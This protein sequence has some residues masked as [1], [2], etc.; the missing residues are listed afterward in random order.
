[1]L[2][3]IYILVCLLG[4]LSPALAQ[5]YTTSNA[6]S[7]N[8]YEQ[9]KPFA[10]AFARNFGSMEAD[11][12]ERNGELYVAHNLKDIDSSRTLKALY[13]QPLQNMI[14]ANKGIFATKAQLQLLID[15][16]TAGEPTMKA[17][18]QALSAFPAITA[19]QQVKIVISGSRPDPAL[20][21]QYPS[22][23]LFDGIPTVIYTPAQ[24]RKIWMISDNFRNYTK[25]NG[26]GSIVKEEKQPIEAVIKKVHALGKK[27]R[28][29][30]TPDNVNTWKTMINLRVDYLN[31]DKVDSL[32][33]YLEKRGTAHLPEP[34]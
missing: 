24:L 28:F 2:R 11:V 26:K 18:I 21:E 16:K 6:H 1:M 33:D 20:W 31:T 5:Q 22:Y 3:H 29:W 7:H 30:A 10:M 12:F 8:D 17:L 13:L 32:A 19:N 25:W 34:R 23:I 4:L 14:D 27:F 9:A 15:F